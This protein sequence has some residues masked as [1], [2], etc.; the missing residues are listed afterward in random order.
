MASRPNSARG[1][2]A[3]SIASRCNGTGR[4]TWNAVLPLD[5]LLDVATGAKA[6]NLGSWTSARSI[7]STHGCA[8]HCHPSPGNLTP[9]IPCLGLASGSGRLGQAGCPKDE[10]SGK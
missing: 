2:I 3:F 5:G 8:A 4:H 7:A 9:A 6:D 1:A 10:V